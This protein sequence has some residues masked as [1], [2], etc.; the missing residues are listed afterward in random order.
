MAHRAVQVDGRTSATGQG[1][2]RGPAGPTTKVIRRRCGRRVVGGA[3]RR[4]VVRAR[5]VRERRLQLRVAQCYAT[6]DR[7]ERTAEQEEHN[8]LCP[9][10]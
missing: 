3:G 2:P 9:V 1:R 4:N 7:R 8:Q 10:V 6:L 5:M